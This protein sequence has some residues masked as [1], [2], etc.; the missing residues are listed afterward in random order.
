MIYF[1]D[2]NICIYIINNKIPHLII[3]YIDCKKKSLKIP[4]L[5]LYELYF[6]AEKSERR[7]QNIANIKVFIAE[8]DIIPF[9]TECAILGGKIR[10]N[11]KRKGQMI[12]D[13]DILIAATVLS[14][15]GTL[16]TNNTREFARIPGLKVQD[17]TIPSS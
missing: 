17:W 8:I 2:T 5:V 1:L 14:A 10:A 6:G 9:D 13:Y 4:S 15:G 7:E 12:G 11:L 16:V 3:R